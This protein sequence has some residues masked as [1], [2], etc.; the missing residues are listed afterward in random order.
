MLLHARRNTN[1]HRW[2]D[3]DENNAAKADHRALQGSVKK[4]PGEGGKGEKTKHQRSLQ[5]SIDRSAGREGRSASPNKNNAS[6]VIRMRTDASWRVQSLKSSA[7]CWKAE[8]ADSACRWVCSESTE[9]AGF[10]KKK[11]G[12][13]LRKKISV[14]QTITGRRWTPDPGGTPQK[15]SVSPV[16]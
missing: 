11:H 14:T 10:E 7:S 2:D 1:P 5:G 8:D 12:A 4:S 16:R 13:R 15:T 6:L 9:G 3:T